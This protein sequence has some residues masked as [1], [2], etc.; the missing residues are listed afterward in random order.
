M[1]VRFRSWLE[2]SKLVLGRD[3][4]G[5]PLVMSFNGGSGTC[6]VCKASIVADGGVFSPNIGLVGE[7]V[8]G[9]RAGVSFF[10]SRDAGVGVLER[11]GGDKIFSL[12]FWRLGVEKPLPDNGRS[13]ERSGDRLSR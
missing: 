3:G 6:I 4:V 1:F 8:E 5:V 11:S 9:R 2:K 7:R 10:G 13:G 12:L